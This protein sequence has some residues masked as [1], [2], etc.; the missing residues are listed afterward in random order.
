MATKYSAANVLPV[1]DKVNDTWAENPDFML[2][3]V[4]LTMFTKARDDAATANS[5]VE[6]KRV[7]LSGLMNDRDDKLKVLQDLVTRARAGFKA[8]YGG[9]STQYEQAGGT[10]ASERKPATRKPK[11]TT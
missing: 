2:G 6:T 9:D 11:P 5:L 10:R 7:E 8:T 4:T 1:A 3:S